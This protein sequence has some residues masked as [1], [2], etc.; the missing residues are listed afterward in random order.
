MPVSHLPSAKERDLWRSVSK[1]WEAHLPEWSQQEH[2]FE[3]AYSIRAINARRRKA[4]REMGP[5][6]FKVP[7]G[8]IVHRTAPENR[9]FVRLSRA[10]DDLVSQPFPT[11]RRQHERREHALHVLFVARLIS[12]PDF[13]W[14]GRYLDD[15][16]DRPRGLF[17]PRSLVLSAPEDARRPKWIELAQQALHEVGASSGAETSP[18]S[19]EREPAEPTAGPRTRLRGKALDAA[20]ASYL[21]RNSNANMAEIARVLGVPRQRLSDPGMTALQAMRAQLQ[22]EAEERREQY[23]SAERYDVLPGQQ[24][25]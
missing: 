19:G 23:A 20:A 1:F 18:A 12:D 11:T 15:G 24:S 4:S 14:E 22:R 16:L 9:S 17:L 25:E 21:A 3:D 7:P 2:W 5:L 10:A 13:E 6:V 8:M